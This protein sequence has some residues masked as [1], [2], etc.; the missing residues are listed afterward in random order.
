MTTNNNSYTSSTRR[1]GDLYVTVTTEPPH[2]T[3][4][5]LMGAVMCFISKENIE[6]FFQELNDIIN[7]YRI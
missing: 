6:S 3:K 4:I 5:E 2:D 7:K 1:I